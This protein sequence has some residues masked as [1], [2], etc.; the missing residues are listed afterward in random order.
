MKNIDIIGYKSIQLNQLT[1]LSLIQT[2]K[3]AP[4][5]SLLLERICL[6]IEEIYQVAKLQY[7]AA[8]ERERARYRRQ[9]EQQK[10]LE[11]FYQQV[12]LTTTKFALLLKGF[13]KLAFDLPPIDIFLLAAG[14]Q[15]L[16]WVKPIPEWITLNRFHPAK[17]TTWKID[18]RQEVDF[19]LPHTGVR[20]TKFI[21]QKQIGRVQCEKV[22]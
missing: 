7:E 3:T 10:L 5:F 22:T 14:Q 21:D 12:F 13:Y 11:Q 1:L 18:R 16:K 15:A 6:L 17:N 19:S 4:Y 8:Q 2:T 20:T 9:M